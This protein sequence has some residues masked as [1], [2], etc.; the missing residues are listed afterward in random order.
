MGFE[1]ADQEQDPHKKMVITL[2]CIAG[3]ASVIGLL[4]PYDPPEMVSAKSRIP[5]DARQVS[6]AGQTSAV[7]VATTT[8]QRGDKR[9]A[10]NRDNIAPAGA[11]TASSA[12]DAA[13]AGD[14]NLVTTDTPT[15][16]IETPTSEE[17]ASINPPQPSFDL[18]RVDEDNSALFAGK[19]APNSSVTLL[20]NGTALGQTQTDSH[21]AFV[22]MLDLPEGDSAM[23]MQLEQGGVT[24]GEQV[25]VIP[26]APNSNAEPQ[27]P[28]I[29]VA[30]AE[31]AEVV[32]DNVT[33]NRAIIADLS[34]DT[35]N[36]SDAG[37]VIL[38]GRGASDQ[39]V[40][41]YVDNHPVSLGAIDDGRWSFEIPNID[42]GIYTLRVDSID[43]TGAV[44]ER[45][46]S[47]FQRVDVAALE[48]AVTIQPGFTLWH[49]AE[50]KYGSGA[51]F[52]QIYE[53]NKDIIKD[54][55]MI[56]PGQVFDLPEN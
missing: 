21:G 51:R 11:S 45:V 7:S 40:R 10:G 29:V 27:A 2:A 35:I 50:Q 33:P 8:D 39:S 16:P 55:D 32:Q 46:E 49:L 47:P 30:E 12:Q 20:G 41:V 14:A 4:W 54:P 24:S 37:H 3:V 15:G 13:P 36:Y 56:F 9:A 1:R 26:Q 43:E 6:D 42:E 22:F 52:V 53:A 25:L 18:L 48:G 31:I 17:S 44:V 34:L 5:A 19:A 23:Q 28:K 38:A